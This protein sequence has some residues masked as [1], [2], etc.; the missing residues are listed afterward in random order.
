MN[1]VVS[2]L[3]V[4]RQPQQ[5][6]AKARFEQVLDEADALLAEA[7]H[8]GF[9]IPELAKRLGYTRASIY[10]FFPTPHAVLN[11]LSGRYLTRLED[12]L[13]ASAKDL[14][15]LSW[16][17]TARTVVNRAAR[18][19]DANPVARLLI[20]GGQMTDDS[21][22][23]QELMI[24]RLGKLLRRLSAQRGII[25]PAGSVDVA[26]LAVEI[27][28]ASF[29]LS[30]FLHGE[31]TDAYREEAAYAIVSYLSRYAVGGSVTGIQA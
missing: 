8:A 10:K 20:L 11:E 24:Q 31:I 13:N 14:V 27:G 6:R 17:E 1:A 2:P 28:T 19:Y 30:Y 15:E 18:F 4:A 9:S 7:G 26:T 25:L 22:R 16:P 5:Q 3:T 21:Y 12:E 29:R 23:A